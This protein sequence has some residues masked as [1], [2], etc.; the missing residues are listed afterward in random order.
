MTIYLENIRQQPNKQSKNE[1]CF[2]AEKCQPFSLK[3]KNEAKNLVMLYLLHLSLN[4]ITVS[5]FLLVFSKSCTFL[6]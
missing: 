1:T 4:Q 6:L 5:I 3:S 2:L